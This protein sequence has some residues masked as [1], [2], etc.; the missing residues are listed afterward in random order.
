MI[1][2]FPCLSDNYG[3]LLHEPV[4]GQTAAI[5]T[6]DANEIA[7]QCEKRGWQLTHI[8]NTHHHYDHTGGNLT[9][10]DK[11]GVQIVGPAAEAEKIPGLDTALK[12]EDVFTFGA[13]NIEFRSTPG[14]TL[15]H[16]VYYVPDEKSVFVGDT[17]FIMGC[18]RLFEGSPKQMYDSLK[19]LAALPEQTQVYCAHEYTLSN[20]KF[21][22]TIEP[23]NL[24]LL[25]AVQRAK[26]LREK[27]EPT[28][29][30]TIGTE[31]KINPFMRAG[32][33]EELGRIR[34]AKDNF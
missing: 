17:L 8:F 31:L 24:D 2:L 19:K 11:Y 18:G 7:R 3:F 26:E 16:G 5:D 30:G 25:K 9:L 22:V 34:A 33:P 23:E 4:S 32:T 27:G 28:V 15:G 20:A 12:D 13:T 10:K 29:P 1:S 21:A 14:H 6:P